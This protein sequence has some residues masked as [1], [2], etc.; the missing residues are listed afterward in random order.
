MNPYIQQ[1][2]ENMVDQVETFAKGCHKAAL[3]DDGSMDVTEQYTIATIER[4]SEEFV[5]G[6]KKIY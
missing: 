4:L 2:V 1:Q 5:K 6:L 3:K